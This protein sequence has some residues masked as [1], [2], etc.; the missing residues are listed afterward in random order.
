MTDYWFS[1]RHFLLSLV[2]LTIV[3]LDCVENSMNNLPPAIFQHWIHS[4][5][6]DRE[7]TQVYRPRGYQFPPSRGRD[8]FEFKPNGEFILSGLGPTDR[9]Q[10]M[11]GTWTLQANNQIKIQ[12]SVWGDAGRV[13][14]VISCNDE[15]LRIRWL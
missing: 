12:V 4:R 11:T 1:R 10:S 15:M 9:P 13:M 5:E 3:Q 7:D 14:E 8:G 6:E 2:G